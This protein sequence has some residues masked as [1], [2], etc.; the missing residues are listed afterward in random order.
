MIMITDILIRM[1]INTNIHISIHMITNKLLGGESNGYGGRSGGLNFGRS[2]GVGPLAR[3]G[4]AYRQG[5]K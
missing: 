1:I 3:Y 4:G 5:G 2:I